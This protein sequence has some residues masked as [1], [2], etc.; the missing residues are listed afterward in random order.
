M[1]ATSDWFL[2]K[3]PTEIKEEIQELAE[4]EHKNANE[5]VTEILEEYLYTLHLGKCF[6]A[7]SQRWQEVEDTLTLF[8][9]AQQENTKMSQKELE[10]LNHN[11]KFFEHKISQLEARIKIIQELLDQVLGIEDD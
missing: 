7:F 6:N 9:V 1:K 2:R 5:K 8:K 3:I 11:L 10:T 4:Q